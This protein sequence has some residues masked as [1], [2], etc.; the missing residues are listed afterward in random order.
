MENGW[1]KSPGLQ[2]SVWWLHDHFSMFLRLHV[3]MSPCLNVSMPP[4]LHV[5]MPTCLHVHV[6]R[7]SEFRKQFRLMFPWPCLHV[8]IS[9]CLLVSMSPWLHDSMSHCLHVSLSPCLI[10]S[11]SHCLHV[12]MSM[13]SHFRN[14]TNRKRN[15]KKMATSFVFCKWKTETANFCL[16]EANENGK[17][18]FVFLG[19]Q[20]I[21]GNRR[22]LFQ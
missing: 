13:S 5:S 18:K 3:S 20:T 9:P 6:F 21:N 7:F 16:L 10:V 11:M 8:S 2:F 14:S 12:S 1:R 15:R 22:L 17:Q 19:Q 4:C